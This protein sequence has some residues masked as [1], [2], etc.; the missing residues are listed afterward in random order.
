VDGLIYLLTSLRTGVRWI[1]SHLRYHLSSFKSLSHLLVRFS[2]PF[3]VYSRLFYYINHSLS[4]AG[5]GTCQECIVQVFY[6]SVFRIIYKCS[7][8]NIKTHQLRRRFISV[9]SIR[10]VPVKTRRSK[11][12]LNTPSSCTGHVLVLG[13]N[14]DERLACAVVYG[15]C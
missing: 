2:A 7:L 11:L 5:L 13:W 14:A 6:C 8:A 15:S 4:N 3:T 10:I 1:D 9:T 12:K